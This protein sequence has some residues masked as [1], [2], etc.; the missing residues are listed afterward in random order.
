MQRINLWK[1]TRIIG[2]SSCLSD[3]IKWLWRACEKIWK[4][5]KIK[6]IALKIWG[7]AAPS[8]ERKW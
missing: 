6:D 7:L 1:E 5:Q 3:A 2:S 8:E 4:T